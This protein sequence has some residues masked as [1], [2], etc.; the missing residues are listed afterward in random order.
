MLKIIAVRFSIVALLSLT[1]ICAFAIADEAKRAL[2][3]PAGD[4]SVA[5]DLL[6][7]QSGGELMY[8]PEQVRGFRTQGAQGD[9]TAR[10]AVALLL[11]GT[12]F[13]VRT[14]ASGAL[15]VVAP[16]KAA[17]SEQA[18]S[19]GAPE[20][21]KEGSGKKFSQDFRVAQVDQGQT[22]NPSTVEKK[23]EQASKRKPVELEEVLVTG[24]HIHGGETAAPEITLGRQEIIASGAMTLEQVLQALPQNLSEVSP[25]ASLGAGVSRIAGANTQGATSIDLHGLGPE[26]TLV[27][28]DGQRMPGSIGGQ[29]FDV[30][31]IPVSTIDHIDV[32]TGGS[33]AFYGSDAVAGVVNI[34]TR[35]RFDGVEAGASVSSNANGYK[36]YDANGTLGA[37]SEKGSFVATLDLS[38]I[39]HFDAS[40]TG[41]LLPVSSIGFST[42]SFWLEPDSSRKSILLSGDYHLS[43][44]VDLYG[45]G[46]ATLSSVKQNLSFSISGFGI[47][48]FDD[49]STNLYSATFGANI[50]VAEGWI[51]NLSGNAGLLDSKEPISELVG[52]TPFTFGSSKD[53]AET[54]TIAAR[55][56]GGFMSP[57]GTEVKVALG[58]ELRKEDLTIVNYGGAPPQG[59]HR[60]IAS[61]YGESQIPILG[62][63]SPSSLGRLV[64]TLAARY[65]HYTDFGSTTNP[66]IGL[67]WT[68]VPSLT[69]RGS[70]SRSFRAPSLFESSEAEQLTVAQVPD[71]NSPSGSSFALERTA[72]NPALD[73]E[74]ARSFTTGIDFHPRPGT[75]VSAS[76]YNID[77][78]NRIDEPALDPR[79]M[80]L[81]PNE[82][83]GLINRTPTAAQL[84]AILAGG[85]PVENLTSQPY[86][87]QTDNILTAFPGLIV[88]D[89]RFHNI[90]K[91]NASG[92]DLSANTSVEAGANTFVF[93]ADGAYYIELKE[94]VT[95]G[96]VLSSVLGTPGRPVKFRARGKLG[97][98][99]G[100]WV[101]NSYLNYTNGYHD[102]YAPVPTNIGSWSTV[103]L[104]LQFDGSRSAGSRALDGLLLTLAVKNLTDKEPPSFRN[105]TFGLGF[106][107]ANSNALGRLVSLNI[108]KHWGP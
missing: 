99:R 87:Q 106:D 29:V 84:A 30:S 38:R 52:G 48:Q 75:R 43:P 4:L 36:T 102:I 73:P 32:L 18:T 2:S 79:L 68:V 8:R 67:I 17:A 65:D 15:L 3:I 94:L 80:V 28:V 41:L 20:Q 107:P 7:K 24:T 51:L 59:A 66:Q 95:A 10:E 47:S 46:I 92:V 25:S 9:L 58:S 26:S 49:N 83:V 40:N 90:G 71:P 53:N 11:Q 39:A 12:P 33:S 96:S 88:L 85:Q 70:Y 60:E 55:I 108:S 37:T 27:L 31:A 101:I 69:F 105:D 82:S 44:V 14:E 50:R 63:Q 103:D 81:S 97:W 78:T 98:G 45:S 21:S 34:V 5:L 35:K 74:T 54:G 19:Q 104:S 1:S 62:G 61:T 89:D 57:W 56:D 42:S 72:G 64:L 23:D 86:N 76:Y 6:A 77:Y 13:Q 100:P 22:S 16:S 93:G 91:L